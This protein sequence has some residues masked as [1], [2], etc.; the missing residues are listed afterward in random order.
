[1]TFDKKKIK[2]NIV[3]IINI[4][5]KGYDAFIFGAPVRGFALS[6]VMRAYLNRLK[7]GINKKAACFVTEFFPFPLMGGN[8]AIDQMKQLCN[9]KGITICGTG[10]VNW[11]NINR[12][13]KISGIME[14]FSRLFC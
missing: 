1:M 14:D 5:F 10:V 13:K 9:S 12:K 4:V 3:N 2:I 11:S 7:A 6:L 8:Q